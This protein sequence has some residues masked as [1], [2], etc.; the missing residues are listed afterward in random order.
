MSKIAIGIV[1]IP[2]QKAS[3]KIVALNSQLE[4]HSIALNMASAIPH[5]TLAMA[6]VRHVDLSIIQAELSKWKASHIFTVVSVSSHLSRSGKNLLWLD[7]SLNKE[8]RVLHLKAMKIRR[9]Y[10]VKG[11]IARSLQTESL[12]PND[13]VYVEGFEHYAFD[14]YTP[15]V[16]LGYGKLDEEVLPFSFE[17]EVKL[18]QLGEHCTLAKLL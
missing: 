9:R 15:H 4:D 1:L 17:A 14:R 18:G 16:T 2:E 7:V 3:E 8:L 10:H 13:L 6:H 12:S 11:A 5:I